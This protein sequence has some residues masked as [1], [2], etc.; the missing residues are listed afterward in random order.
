MERK[1]IPS[2]FNSLQASSHALAS[3]DEMYTLAPFVT[4]PSDI[5]RPIPLAPP[6][7]RTTLSY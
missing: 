1:Q 5:I 7:T 3:R 4:K 6:V 2:A